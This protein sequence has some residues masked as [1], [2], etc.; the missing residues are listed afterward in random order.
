MLTIP[1]ILTLIRLL[2][3]PCFIAASVRGMFTAAFVLF[4]S[5]AATDILDGMIARRLN[6]GSR[7]GA[8]LDPAADK[9]MMLAGYLF[10]TL[11]NRPLLR[12]P[13]WLTFL[14][15]V[16]DFMIVTFAYLLYTRVHVKRF[17]PS[18]A[19]KTSTLLQAAA[20]AGTIG[21][22]AF[23][24]VLLPLTQVLLRV[25]LVVTL[26]SSWDYLRRGE[27]LLDG[28]LAAARLDG[29]GVDS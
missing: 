17:P 28:G 7:I 2:L 8:L 20:L 12:V 16:R 15:L 9:T 21:V 24:T 22:N 14:V 13:G 25:A 4:V 29:A 11:S 6:Q 19:G 27:R 10:Y 26:Y 3:V 23:G 5:A 1:N 18:I